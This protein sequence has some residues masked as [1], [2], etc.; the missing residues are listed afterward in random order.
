MTRML[1]K[2]ATVVDVR[3]EKEREEKE[4][5]KKGSHD[6]KDAKKEPSSSSSAPKDEKNKDET[7]GSAAGAGL[8][9]VE[10]KQ[11]EEERNQHEFERNQKAL[12]TS[13]ILILFT[14]PV[15]A[16]FA[17][18]IPCRQMMRRIKDPGTQRR[19][20]LRRGALAG[21]PMSLSAW[22]YCR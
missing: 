3:E 14:N 22:F 18:P 21:R 4:A 2:E 10:R 6:Q 1:P 12:M 7:A 16:D 15:R 5:R 13:Q 8:W 11:Y 9:E 19:R 17:R 20:S